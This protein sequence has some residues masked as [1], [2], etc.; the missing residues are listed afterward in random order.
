MSNPKPRR[1]RRRSDRGRGQA[2]VEFAFVFPIFVVV[3]ASIVYFGL[4]LFDKM[5]VINAAREAARAAAIV[6]DRTTIPVTA[7]QTAQS[8]AAQGGISVA[9]S[10]VTVAC[11]AIKSLPASCN[12][13]SATSSKSGDA[14][15]V[16][17]TYPF[18]NPW[19]LNISLPGNVHIALP[20]SFNLSSTVQMVLE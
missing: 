3:V 6:S 7:P 15:T 4:M 16:T 12:F 20:S 14:V 19:P 8:V 9:T 5:T 18:S 11:V 2:M 13:S 17:V 1:F 10:N